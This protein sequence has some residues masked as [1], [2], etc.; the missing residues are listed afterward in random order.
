MYKLRIVV[1]QEKEPL[2]KELLSKPPKQIVVDVK[3]TK[4]GKNELATD[5]SH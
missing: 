3:P 1:A 2:V 4:R 5:K